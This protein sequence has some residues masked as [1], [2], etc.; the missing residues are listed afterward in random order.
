MAAS[1]RL[2]EALQYCAE[3]FKS[4]YVPEFVFSSFFSQ[5]KLVIFDHRLLLVTL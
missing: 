5:K 4:F 2:K 3:Q 1:G